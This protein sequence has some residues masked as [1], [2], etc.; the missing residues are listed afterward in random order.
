MLCTVLLLE[1][2]CKYCAVPDKA[3]FNFVCQ[4]KYLKACRIRSFLALQALYPN[5]SR[6]LFGKRI[7]LLSVTRSS[8]IFEDPF[9]P[10]LNSCSFLRRN[11]FAKR[12]SF[13]KRNTAIACITRYKLRRGVFCVQ[14][15]LKILTF[16][17][18]LI[19]F[20]RQSPCLFFSSIFYF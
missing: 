2:Y 3:P 20:T 17:H 19:I 18:S 13:G 10:V 9:L 5:R 11:S 14:H 6:N 12:N 15:W 7:S 16:L 8:L 4:T 1:Y